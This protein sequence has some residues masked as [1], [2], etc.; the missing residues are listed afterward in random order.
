MV[1]MTFNIYAMSFVK[2]TVF[3]NMT[4]CNMV[5]LCLTIW[6]YIHIHM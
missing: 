5:S 2:N 6:H 4:T 3:W 1:V